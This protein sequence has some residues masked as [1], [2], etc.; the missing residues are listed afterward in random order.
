MR[1]FINVFNNRLLWSYYHVE[2][3][4]YLALYLEKKIRDASFED[5]PMF[6]FSGNI[7]NSLN[8]LEYHPYAIS[9]CMK[10]NSLAGAEKLLSHYL[11][12]TVSIERDHGRRWPIDNDCCWKISSH[13]KSNPFKLGRNTV[14]GRHVWLLGETVSI[15]LHYHNNLQWQKQLRYTPRFTEKVLSM[16]RSILPYSFYTLFC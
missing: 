3:A 5:K 13:T 6:D 4:R 11:K 8:N 1:E 14:I 2:V 9:L 16:S 15:I 10:T 12:S 7:V